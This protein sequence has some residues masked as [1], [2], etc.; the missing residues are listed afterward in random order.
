MFVAG[1]I[2]DPFPGRDIEIVVHTFRDAGYDRLTPLS[3]VAGE[4]IIASAASFSKSPVS[5]SGR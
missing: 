1:P 3:S 2:G 5:C 4:S